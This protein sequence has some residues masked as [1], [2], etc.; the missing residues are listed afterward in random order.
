MD[1]RRALQHQLVGQ[2]EWGLEEETLTLQSTDWS[3][4]WSVL[5]LHSCTQNKA[6]IIGIKNRLHTFRGFNTRTII[7][8]T[9]AEERR[10]KTEQLQKGNQTL[11]AVDL[12]HT[13]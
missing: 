6:L 2:A 13:A 10:I 8:I 7:N 12:L 5:V 11:L 1:V 4:A 9:A 3:P